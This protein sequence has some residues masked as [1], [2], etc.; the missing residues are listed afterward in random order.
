MAEMNITVPLGITRVVVDIER[1]GVAP[2]ESADLTSIPPAGSILYQGATY[3]ITADK[4]AAVNGN[5]VA[6]TSGVV[7]LKL[8]KQPKINT[9]P[10]VFQ[11]NGTDWY[12]PVTP[13]SGGPHVPGDPSI[14]VVPPVAGVPAQAAAA[15]YNTL[16]FGPKIELGKNWLAAT[17]QWTT[18]PDGSV[19]CM[20]TPGY[21]YNAL[22]ATLG[23]GSW[24]GVCFGKGGY[25]EATFKYTGPP[26]FGVPVPS[27]WANDI[28]N[29]LQ[30]SYG[31]GE[32]QWPGQP[33][34][35]VDSIEWDIVEVNNG[36]GSMGFTV[37]SWFGFQSAIQDT[38]AISDGSPANGLGDQTQYHRYGGL[39]VPATA[40]SKGYIQHYF[41]DRPV[42]NRIEWNQYNP[43]L[44]PPPREGRNAFSRIDVSHMYF[45]IGTGPNNPT[46]Y[47]GVRIWQRDRS[48]NIVRP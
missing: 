48:G 3:T 32:S 21:G 39:W 44:P 13:A 12:G 37:H 30:N 47:E 15:G 1:T 36:A 6:D 23:S 17:G 34:G 28:E 46:T 18:N 25:Y 43:A 31:T 38:M 27:F 4:K 20:G 5:P 33:K 41:D 24:R 45:I 26:P 9:P 7:T 22:T 10:G 8:V 42:G 29:Q 19:T 40:S 11:N 16:T 14:G 2:G 35:Y